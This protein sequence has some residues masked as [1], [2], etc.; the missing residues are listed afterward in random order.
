[1]S[2]IHEIINNNFISVAMIIGIAIMILENRKENPHGTDHIA[3]IMV[4]LSVIG[5]RSAPFL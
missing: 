1:M 3:V 2:T 5:L 4:L